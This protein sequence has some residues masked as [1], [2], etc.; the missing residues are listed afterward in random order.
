MTVDI[1]RHMQ[2]I[3]EMLI[4]LLRGWW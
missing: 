1:S 2:R 3:M 4:T